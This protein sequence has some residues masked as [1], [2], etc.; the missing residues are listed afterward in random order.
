MIRILVLCAVDPAEAMQ[1]CVGQS[2]FLGEAGL[3]LTGQGVEV[4]CAAPG[5]AEGYRPVPGA[6]EPTAVADI[7]AVYDRSHVR[8]RRAQRQWEGLG[9]P[10][11]NPS[12]FSD[13]CDDKLT[14]ARF[15]HERGL[16]VPR[17][18]AAADP[19]WR[20][21]ERAF[22]KPRYGDRARGVRPVLP[23]EALSGGIVQE[24]HEPVEPGQSIRILMQR[25]AG[26]GWIAA[27]MLDR[28]AEDAAAVVS[29][30]RGAVARP[31]DP[32][33]ATGL[34]PLIAATA[35]ILDALPDAPRIVE[36]GVDV[37]VDRRG[38]WVL[39][40]NARPGRSFDRMGRPDLRT[41]AV[42]RPFAR[43]LERLRGP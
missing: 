1:R 10:V 22:A 37:V 15:A 32:D 7:D 2:R 36:V 19:A 42:N 3:G 35:E 29:L 27:G 18:V 21:W 41:A 17:T 25:D 38:P 16:P 34:R 4:V 11:F 24:G 20:R 40:W 28:R 13:L 26:G 43:M 23:H 31:V 30:S 9:V 33:V 39:E 14:F 8:P 12:S 5:E 6:W